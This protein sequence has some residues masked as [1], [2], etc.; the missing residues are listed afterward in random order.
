MTAKAPQEVVHNRLLPGEQDQ[1]DRYPQKEENGFRP[2][3]MESG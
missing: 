3:D 2:N 1:P